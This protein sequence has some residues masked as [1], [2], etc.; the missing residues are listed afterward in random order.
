M[1]GKVYHPIS[2]ERTEAQRGLNFLRDEQKPPNVSSTQLKSKQTS[3][4][5]DVGKRGS[6]ILA[7]WNAK[8]FISFFK[9][10]IWAFHKKLVIRL[11]YVP[12]IL[13]FGIYS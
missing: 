10:I 5:V 12:A 11:S 7:S 9:E 6:S 3:A 1:H 8:W 4:S 13:H 2:Y